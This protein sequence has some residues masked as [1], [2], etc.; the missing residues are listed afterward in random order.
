MTATKAKPAPSTA[1][2]STACMCQKTNNLAVLGN[3]RHH[4][5]G[6]CLVG[7]LDSVP[8]GIVDVGH[9]VDL[10]PQSVDDSLV[11]VDRG[12]DDGLVVVVDALND[13]TH[14][15]VLDGVLVVVADNVDDLVHDVDGAG[16]LVDGL[17]DVVLDVLLG[18]DDGLDDCRRERVGGEWQMRRYVR[19]GMSGRAKLQE[20]K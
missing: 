19:Q 8:L 5:L 11:H 1:A 13:A 2:A 20:V 10:G 18:L 12:L 7:I 17:D 15:A 9:E 16:D 4:S 14:G 6:L 3:N